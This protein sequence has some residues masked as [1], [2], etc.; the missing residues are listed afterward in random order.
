VGNRITIT[1]YARKILRS[2]NNTGKTVAVVI[3][4]SIRRYGD[5]EREVSWFRC[6]AWDNFAE[7]ILSSVGIGDGV[8]IV[9]S[10]IPDPKTGNP[11][12]YVNREGETFTRYEV[13][14]TSFDVLKKYE[15]GQ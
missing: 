12:L 5:D 6:V 7:R 2:Q 15:E 11:K 1:G 8:R 3:V 13:R 10:I 9:G 4:R 14:I